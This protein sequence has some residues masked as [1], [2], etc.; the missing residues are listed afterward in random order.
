MQFK[1]KWVRE[2]THSIENHRQKQIQQGAPSN[3]AQQVEEQL[4]LSESQ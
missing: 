3:L 4:G 2:N 1:T